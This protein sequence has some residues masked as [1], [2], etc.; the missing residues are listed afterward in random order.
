MNSLELILQ[1]E[2]IYNSWG[3]VLVFFASLVETSPI[4][5]AIPGGLIVALGGFFAYNNTLSLS[6]I[7]IAGSSGM[8]ITFILAYLLGKKTGLILAKKL[9]QEFFAEQAKILL[10]NHG[11]VILTTSLLAT[12]TRFWVSYVAGVEKYNLIKFIFYAALAA[13]TWNSLL[14]T[15]GYLA[16]SERTN[17]ET[18]LSRFGILSWGLVGLAISIIYIKAK[19]EF[20]SLK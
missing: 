5:F 2:H 4:G 14:V 9:K 17:L 10:K 7:I 3:Y 13:L 12:L 1:L 8:L 18:W 11:A 6:G 19:R 20:K 16:G 15:I